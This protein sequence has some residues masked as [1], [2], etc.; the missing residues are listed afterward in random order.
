[1][2]KANSLTEFVP[3]TRIENGASVTIHTIYHYFADYA[4]KL[5]IPVEFY[6]SEVVSGSL[7]NKTKEECMVISHLKHPTDYLN[8]CVRVK[9]QGQQAF[10][11]VSSYGT[12]AQMAK[13]AKANA[14]RQAGKVCSAAIASLGHN[15]AKYE[16]EQMYYESIRQMCNKLTA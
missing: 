3:T 13:A 2:I 9:H 14:K 4:K 8:F 15:R 11:Y 12:S 7:I 5:G 16:E 10:V 6:K 1:M